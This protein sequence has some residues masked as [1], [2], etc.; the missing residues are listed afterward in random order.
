MMAGYLDSDRIDTS[1]VVDGWFNTGDLAHVAEDGTIA[2][3]G[4]ESETI[5][6]AGMK[7]VP[8]EVEEIIS[9][10]PGVREAKVYAG[11]LRSGDQ[12]IKA[13]IVSSGSPDLAEFRKH[14]E[15]HLI[16]YKRPSRFLFV[17]SLPKTASGKIILD[18]LP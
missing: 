1:P 13:A 12:F 2:L 10:V 14:C 17:D 18:R 16:Y 11:R 3:R 9:A 6:V 4:R 7:V 15:Q 8:S 5:N